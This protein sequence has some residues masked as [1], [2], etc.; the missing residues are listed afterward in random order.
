MNDLRRQI[1]MTRN[2]LTR[3]DDPPADLARLEE[4]FRQ[5]GDRF[6]ETYRAWSRQHAAE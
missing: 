1:W 4:Q 6:V 5:L 3:S 2:G